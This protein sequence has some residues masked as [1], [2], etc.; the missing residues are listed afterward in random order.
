MFGERLTAILKENKLNKVSFLEMFIKKG[1]DKQIT[2]DR[3]TRRGIAS[4]VEDHKMFTFI[5]GKCS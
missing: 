1:K 2:P 3:F 4:K 5:Y